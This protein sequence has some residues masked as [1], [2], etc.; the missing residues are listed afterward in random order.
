MAADTNNQLDGLVE[1]PLQQAAPAHL[2]DDLVEEPLPE[3]SKTVTPPADTT[4]KPSFVD[5]MKS[6]GSKAWEAVNTPLMKG[7]NEEE[8][9]TK[10]VKDYANQAP[11]LAESE[12]P[13]ATGIRKG[14]AGA[15][16][17]TVDTL[18]GLT[19][20][21][22]M[23]TL[24]AGPAAEAEGAL[25][26]LGK[27]ASKAAAGTFAGEGLHQ[28]GKGARQIYED[29]G[30]TPENTKETLGGLGTAAM[31]TVGAL[32]GT[33][34]GNETVKSA[35]LKP[36][37]GVAKAANAAADVPGLVGYALGGYKG[38]KIAG[39]LAP[40]ARFG[41]D[42]TMAGISEPDRLVMKQREAV[43]PFQKALDNA[44]AEFDSYKASTAA[45]VPVPEKVT[46]AL[47]KAKQGLLEQ[48]KHL[49]LAEQYAANA[50]AGR[51]NIPNA[52]EQPADPNI[53]KGPEQFTPGNLPEQPAAGA[54]PAPIAP[55]P[56][57]PSPTREVATG[58]SQFE[59][60]NLPEQPARPAE[61]TPAPKP[62]GS[63]LPTRE[64]AT[65]AAQFEPENLPEQ[66][67]EAPLQHKAVRQGENELGKASVL[68][69]KPKG[70]G[71][72]SALGEEDE[73]IT[74]NKVKSSPGTSMSP[75][76]R[77]KVEAPAA[78]ENKAA[79]PKENEAPAPKHINEIDPKELAN[80]HN[81]NRG[82]TYNAEKGF[83]RDQ[84]GFSVAGEHP[85]LEEVIKGQKIS[86]EDIKNYIAR[87][88][89]QEALKDPKNSVGGWF[90]KGESHLEISKLFDNKDDAIAEGKRL[91]QV[92]IYDHAAHAGVPTGGTG[93][94]E[95]AAAKDA[96]PAKEAPKE[97]PK[98]EAKKETFGE[99]PENTSAAKPKEHQITD[100]ES[101]EAVDFEHHVNNTTPMG[102][103]AL[104]QL[105]EFAAEHTDP[106]KTVKYL[107]AGTEA[108]VYDLG[109]DKVLRVS[110]GDAPDVVD[111]PNVLKPEATKNVPA[112]TAD[113]EGFHGAIY[114]KVE[115]EG[116]TAEDVKDMKAKLAAEGNHWRDASVD[117]L[118]RT[119]DGKFVV[120]D[121][122]SI[123][124]GATPGKE[125]GLAGSDYKEEG[126]ESAAELHPVVEEQVSKLSNTKLQELGKTYGLNPDEYNF[127]RR[128]ALREGGSKHPVERHQFIRDLMGAMP[129]DEKLDIGRRI[130]ADEG[131][132]EFAD[133]DTSSKGKADQAETYFPKL[134]EQL[135]AQVGPKATPETAKMSDEELLNHGF[136][137]EQIDAGR[138]IPTARGGTEGKT[139]LPDDV[140]RLLTPE[141]KAGITKSEAG[142]NTAI[143]K[144]MDMPKVQDFADIALQ[145][146]GGRKWYQRS[147]QAF[148][149]LTKALPEYF[150]EGDKGKFTDLLAAGSPQQTVKMNLQ[151]ALKVWT[152]YVDQD[153]PT[154]KPL[155]KML[156]QEFTLPGA[157]T[158]NAIKAL[159]GE[160]LWPDISKNSNFK[161]P[162]FAANLKGWLNHVTSDGWQGLFAG[163]DAKD[164][165]R[166]TSY[167]PLAVATRAAA[168]ALGWEPAE[169][170]AAIWAFT[171]AFTE[172]GET[173][174]EAIKQYSQDFADIIANDP[175]IQEQL[176]ELGV[177]QE[178]L[179]EHLAKVE[180]KP[181]VSGRTTPTTAN[182]IARLSD[183]IEKAGRDLPKSKDQGNL[184]FG[185]EVEKGDTSF[186]PDE[187][188]KAKPT[189]IPKAKEF[190]LKRR[191]RK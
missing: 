65:G 59:P 123:D 117:N 99:K 185:K 46:A 135:K 134:R 52:A 49:D 5:R 74:P 62:L 178:T 169:A 155:E 86:P 148:D 34:L 107:N 84:P 78:E 54:E 131:S 24:A 96:E 81:E 157:K 64:V 126:G 38:A 151:E 171:K 13:I 163:I 44:Q 45:G 76:G 133:R 125:P 16:G 67:P 6:I 95:E 40:E 39:A 26:T 25:G 97:E 29:K 127:Q 120:T 111:S 3:A 61:E 112:A 140:S 145:G 158:P 165:S 77:A 130:K 92:E 90:H 94:Y 98:E 114:P 137:Q 159:A 115:T 50:K 18:R 146:E 184:N 66:N 142:R 109:N 172:H 108:S 170:Q 41:E 82:F 55:K 129:E 113:A 8:E 21:L 160:D 2:S 152:K 143:Q 85:E 188:E 19:S 119:K 105:R 88:D 68:K 36:V 71:F 168:E 103:S 75:E 183:R 101:E 32:H 42:I 128:E 149:A 51:P 104:R 9:A 176:K 83:M 72:G 122:G 80:Y 27:V 141:E 58:A 186:N 121:P 73:E 132:E 173:D 161:V 31:G 153:R 89:V 53:A 15:Y 70:E 12:H 162:S 147:T 43:V 166:A 138:H 28:A 139:D 179:N 118:G 191:I 177:N 23:A 35:A 10:S 164:L 182:S 33:A 136:T 175:D 106:S 167:H 47:V 116:I 100:P 124:K 20:P 144:L 189:E 63:A 11:T 17:D 37:R 154:G 190:K 60:G 22:G 150:K 91:N 57:G 56:F 30:L 4:D 7:S 187:L 110:T 102:P 1:E 156:R 79:A 180:P 14:I 174:P 48:Q 93:G 87:P 181:E 69:T